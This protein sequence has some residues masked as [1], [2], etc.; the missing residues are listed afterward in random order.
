M[1]NL[2]IDAAYE[3]ATVPK[4][5]FLYAACVFCPKA[6]YVMAKWWFLL[7]GPFQIK[8]GSRNAQIRNLKTI[9][10]YE[11]ATVRKYEVSYATVRKKEISYAASFLFAKKQRT[12]WRRHEFYWLGLFQSNLALET[13]KSETRKSPQ[14]KKMPPYESLNFRTWILLVGPFSIKLGFRNA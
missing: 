14:H 6:A 5:E 9:A 10:F 8:L 3:N 2:K 11:N 12:S 4:F 13:R 7:V 1:R